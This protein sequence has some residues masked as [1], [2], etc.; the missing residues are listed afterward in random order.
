MP[1]R[2]AGK[3]IP[4]V[5]ITALGGAIPRISEVIVGIRDLLL[6]PVEVAA[7]IMGHDALLFIRYQHFEVKRDY[8]LLRRNL[9]VF[10]TNSLKY[11]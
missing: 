7:S 11:Y 10:H 8:F 6:I 9:I 2:A 1:L 5:V 3:V 4:M